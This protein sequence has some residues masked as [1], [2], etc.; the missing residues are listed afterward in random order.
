MDHVK[1][2]HT[3]THSRSCVKRRPLLSQWWMIMAW[4][5][6]LT[7]TPNIFIYRLPLCTMPEC[8]CV[9]V[10]G[11]DRDK[12]CV[13][14]SL[15]S[16][17]IKHTHTHTAGHNSTHSPLSAPQTPST[18]ASIIQ[19]VSFGAL[20]QG[21]QMVNVA[22]WLLAGLGVSVTAQHCPLQVGPVQR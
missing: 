1:R 16:I 7:H 17:S 10:W 21:T 8:V 9:C 6:F 2:A 13:S 15:P 5:G 18:T 11:R 19:S 14:I 4:L 12:E 20:P 22:V 3:H